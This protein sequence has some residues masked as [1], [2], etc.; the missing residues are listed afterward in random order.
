MDLIEELVDHTFPS[1]LS[2]DF[3]QKYLTYF[4]MNFDTDRSIDE[5]NALLDSSPSMDTNK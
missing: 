2:D 5:F 1:N 4:G 3:L